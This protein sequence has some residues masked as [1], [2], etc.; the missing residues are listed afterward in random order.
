MLAVGLRFRK[1]LQLD[2]VPPMLRVAVGAVEEYLQRH[3]HITAEM[4]Q[5]IRLSIFFPQLAGKA[6]LQTVAVQRLQRHDLECHR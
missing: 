6:R 3:R 2:Q 5:R 1:L 4:A